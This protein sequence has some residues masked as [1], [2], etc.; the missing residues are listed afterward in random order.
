MSVYDRQIASAIRL[1]KAKGQTVTWKKTNLVQDSTQPWKTSDPS[2]A[3]H[4]VAIV[5]LKPQSDFRNKMNHLLKGTDVPNGGVR[6]LMG[7]VDFTPDLTDVVI[8]N[9]VEMRIMNFD[10]IAPNGDAILYDI[11][12]KA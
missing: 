3:M 11:E 4:S 6:G 10:V 12:F 9:E 8:R 1:I 7:A 5:F 2:A